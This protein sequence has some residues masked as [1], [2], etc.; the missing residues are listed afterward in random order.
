[1]ARAIPLV[2]LSQ[3]HGANRTLPDWGA[4]PSRSTRGANTELA[5]AQ[6]LGTGVEADP[7]NIFI[8]NYTM[9]CPLA[10][11]YCC[12]TCGPKQIGRAHV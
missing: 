9:K 6:A 8:L 5:I 3:R 11:D 2:D 12:Y 7:F 1:M 4:T 10:C